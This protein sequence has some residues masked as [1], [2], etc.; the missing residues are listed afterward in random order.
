MTFTVLW[1]L[2]A[3]SR[4]ANVWLH[5]PDRRAVSAAADAID[6]LLRN[7]AQDAGESR[8]GNRRIIHEPPLG[9]IV[10]VSIPEQ[11]VLVLDVWRYEK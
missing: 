6:R 5:A 4:L 11:I 3:E 9:V 7:N 1:S 10:S 8:E 2:N